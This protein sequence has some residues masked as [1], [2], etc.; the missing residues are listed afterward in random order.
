[1]VFHISDIHQATITTHPSTF[2][3]DMLL[4]VSSAK[5]RAYQ[6]YK[7]N[8]TVPHNCM[9]RKRS[10]RALWTRTEKC[11]HCCRCFQCQYRNCRTVIVRHRCCK[12]RIPAM[13][14]NQISHH[15]IWSSFLSSKKAAQRIRAWTYRPVVGPAILAHP[16]S[17]VSAKRA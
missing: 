10:V 17:I 2:P 13:N 3:L 4:T 15:L 6:T 12:T 7:S 8:R 5:A 11:V 16:W 1:M 14:P 9:Y